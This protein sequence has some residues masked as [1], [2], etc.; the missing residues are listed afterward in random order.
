[1]PSPA[2]SR[3]ESR[4]PRLSYRAD[5]DGL[6]AVAV[7]AI[8]GFHSTSRIPGGFVGVDIFFVISGF[9]ITSLIQSGLANGSFTLG[10]FYARRARRIF[11]AL[12]VVL[13]VTAL[14]GAAV[15]LPD[16]FRQLGRHIIGGVFF[17]SNFVL[18]GETGYFDAA[19]D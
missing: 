19:A 15:L 13:L 10:D 9:L 16:E 3:R 18:W 7:L 12:A 2:P 5:L 6:R 17:A 4:S 11:P 14:L 8:L 1:M